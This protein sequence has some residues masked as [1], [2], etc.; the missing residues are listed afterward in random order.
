L[1][2]HRGRRDRLEWVYRSRGESPEE[3]VALSGICELNFA[4]NRLESSFIKDLVYFLSNDRWLRSLN[5]RGNLIDEVGIELLNTMLDRNH[6]LISLDIRDNP[7]CNKKLSSVI[8][9]KLL[10][11]MKKV[12][13]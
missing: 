3:D 9:A 7:G 11:N 10:R 4:E 6:S 2:E 5:L 8:Y 13:E 1:E 12:K